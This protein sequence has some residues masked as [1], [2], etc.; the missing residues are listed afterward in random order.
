MHQSELP[1]DCWELKKDQSYNEDGVYNID[2]GGKTVSVYC[3]MTTDGGGWTAIQRYL[4]HVLY[5]YI[6]A[7]TIATIFTVTTF[8][9]VI[10]TSLQTHGRHGRFQPRL[11]D[12]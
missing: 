2:V 7:L 9:V 4:T 10:V 3:D 12:L 1:K 8:I 5:M 11:Q 6:V